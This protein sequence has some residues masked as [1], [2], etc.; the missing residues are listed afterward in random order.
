VYSCS[1]GSSHTTCQGRTAH[2]SRRRRR[3]CTNRGQGRRGMYRRS[4]TSSR[5]RHRSCTAASPSHSRT[6]ARPGCRSTV[7][8]T[9]H[10]RSR[11][12]RCACCPNPRCLAGVLRHNT[13][14]SPNLSLRSTVTS[15]RCGN[16]TSTSTSPSWRTKTSEAQPPHSAQQLINDGAARVTLLRATARWKVRVGA[17]LGAHG[18]GDE[19]DSGKDEPEPE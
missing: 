10:L 8:H 1:P 9:P 5:S 14:G 11:N 17:R 18:R 19:G 2:G 7:R 6:A 15:R 12:R 16:T 4:T 13:W 3:G